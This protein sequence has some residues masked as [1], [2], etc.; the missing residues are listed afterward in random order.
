LKIDARFQVRSCAGLAAGKLD[1]R[2]DL[3]LYHCAR[4]R[5][6][7]FLLQHRNGLL[8]VSGGNLIESNIGR[9]RGK[10]SRNCLGGLRQ[11]VLISGCFREHNAFLSINCAFAIQI[12]DRAQVALHFRDVPLDPVGTEMRSHSELVQMHHHAQVAR[13]R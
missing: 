13:L 11:R 8:R 6:Q 7:N 1:L 5:R 9:N 4:L 12:R 2:R 3:V 10:Q